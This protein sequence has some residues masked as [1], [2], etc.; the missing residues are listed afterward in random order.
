MV[1]QPWRVKPR[2]PTLLRSSAPT[3]RPELGVFQPRRHSRHKRPQRASVSGAAEGNPRPPGSAV[4]FAERLWETPAPE[5]EDQNE[6]LAGGSRSRF[7]PFER[8]YA[9]PPAA[10]LLT[11]QAVRELASAA[12]SPSMLIV[13]FGGE[14]GLCPPLPCKG[15]S[16]FP[17]FL[18]SPSARSVQDR[19]GSAPG[20]FCVA[21]SAPPRAGVPPG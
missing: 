15:K 3:L 19:R 12:P 4:G 16:V 18:R 20:G 9:K 21:P 1:P 10:A 6:P 14:R 8:R 7:P 13:C 11:G 17:S 2:N 5:V